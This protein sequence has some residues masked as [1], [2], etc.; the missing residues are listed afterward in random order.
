MQRKKIIITYVLALLELLTANSASLL[1]ALAL[2]QEGLRDEDLVLGGDGAV[3]V[4]IVC[5]QITTISPS[6]R[7]AAIVPHSRLKA[8]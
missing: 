3:K 7:I 5:P 1:L 6:V 2:L 8:R 4:S